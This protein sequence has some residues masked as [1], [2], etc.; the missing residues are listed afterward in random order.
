MQRGSFTT[1]YEGSVWNQGALQK[2]RTYLVETQ[3]HNLESTQAAKSLISGNNSL[4]VGFLSVQ[5]S[6]QKLQDTAF[7]CLL[8]FFTGFF[9]HWE[10]SCWILSTLGTQL[11][12]WIYLIFFSLHYFSCSFC[13]LFHNW[14]VEVWRFWL[15]IILGFVLF[16]G[17]YIFVSF[18]CPI[19]SACLIFSS[20]L[21]PFLQKIS[22]GL[23]FIVMSNICGKKLSG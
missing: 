17:D 18:A 19:Y 4:K 21:T 16:W 23:S 5:F 15:L 22:I 13:C 10:H 1:R 2:H 3:L 6:E 7:P 20:S 14:W 11:S 8:H 12:L 9:Q